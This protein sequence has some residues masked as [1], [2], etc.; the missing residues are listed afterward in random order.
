M[1]GEAQKLRFHLEPGAPE[2]PRPE[3]PR[4][5]MWSLV[6]HMVLMVPLIPTTILNAVVAV[7]TVLYLW[8]ALSSQPG[9]RVA[10]S[11]GT[12][13]VSAVVLALFLVVMVLGLALLTS[14]MVLLARTILGHRSW[15]VILFGA[16][17]MLAAGAAVLVFTGDGAAA[18]A[19][20]FGVYVYVAAVALGHLLWPIQ[21]STP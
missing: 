14:T 16:V 17:G 5:G 10:T 13:P 7:L 15:R 1:G 3:P 20:V 6:V 18:T 2:P 21:R 11:M 4:V 19:A 8:R 12:A 9:H